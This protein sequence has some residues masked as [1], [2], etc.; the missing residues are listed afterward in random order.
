MAS[1]DNIKSESFSKIKEIS[2]NMKEAIEERIYLDLFFRIQ[3]YTISQ[4]REFILAR[5]TKYTYM[6]ENNE[7][8]E[9]APRFRTQPSDSEIQLSLFFNYI[10]ENHPDYSI[11]PDF[12]K[13]F[14]SDEIIKPQVSF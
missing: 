8:E 11:E 5:L 7:F 2:K 4:T 6:E 1:L 10:F 9:R 3:N 14:Y 13:L 12:R